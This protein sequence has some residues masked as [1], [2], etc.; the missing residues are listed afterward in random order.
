M[1]GIFGFYSIKKDNKDI[2]EKVKKGLALMNHRGP[3]ERKIL[4]HKNFSCGTNRLSIESISFGA[5]PI[6]D[7]EY[8]AGFNGEIFNYK[9]LIKQFNLR[10]SKSEID[11]ILHLWK[12]KKFKITNFIKGQ[13]AI[14]I[15]EKKNENLYIFRDPFGIRPLYYSFNSG[16][17]T[18]S[19]EIKS[20]C[21][22]KINEFSLDPLSFSQTAMFWVNIGSQTSFKNILNLQPGHFLVWDKKKIIIKKH[23]EFP[24]FKK[25]NNFSYDYLPLDISLEKSVLNQ[26]HGEVDYGC[27]LSGGIDSSIIAYILSKHKK[28]LKTFSISFESDEYDESLYQRK[29]SKQLNSEHFELRITN[30]MIANNFEKTVSHSENLLFRTAPVPMYLLSKL[31][32]KQNIKVIYSGEGADEILFGYD[33]F[34][35]NRI[36][37]FWS[38]LPNSKIRFKL[39]KKLYNYLPQFKNSRYFEI[40]KDFYKNDLNS[41]SLFYSHLVR[42][43]QFKHVSSFFNLDDKYLDEK[44]LTNQFKKTLP[45]NFFKFNSDTQNQKIE[46]DTLLSNY[47]LSS[48][49]DRMS[50]ANSVEGRYP[51]LDEDFV[52][53]ACKI[54]SKKLAPGISS[55]KLLRKSFLKIIPEEILFRPKTAYQAPEARAFINNK[56]KSE[57]IEEILDNINNLELINKNNFL[58]LISKLQDDNASNRFGF[59]ENMAFTMALSYFVLKKKCLEWTN[60]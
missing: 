18:F 21:Q 36:R 51:Y 40:V 43:S 7:D 14:F 41:N 44:L 12:I 29:I 13:Y 8:I 54:G 57:I 58:S 19:S 55:K 37:K 23:Y 42:W 6:E 39:L 52:E 50:M 45:R 59:R 1:C 47:L 31:V 38:R 32:N 9:T 28:N 34:F 30:K 60:G 3:D 20:I 24:S 35:E 10:N 25:I 11:L 16:E 26:M 17:F 15:Y 46:I 22:T 48:Q 27:Y 5:Q 53:N 49:G 2:L 56:F 4:S 33:I